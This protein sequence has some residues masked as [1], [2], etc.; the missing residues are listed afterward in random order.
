MAIIYPYVV[1]CGC[2]ATVTANLADGVNVSRTPAIRREILEGRFHKV[3]CPACGTVVTAEKS[4]FYTDLDRQTFIQVKPRQDRHLSNSV[5]AG[6]DRALEYL[7]EALSPTDSRKV[8][9]VFGMAELREK[10]LAED[11]DL[12]DRSVEYLKVLV[13]NEHPFLLQK[14]R[15]RLML[16]GATNDELQFVAAFDL[17]D[18][19]FRVGIPLPAGREVA[20]DPPLLKAWSTDAGHSD[21]G[22]A[23]NGNH[24]VNMWRWSP[25]PGALEA[26]QGFAAALRQGNPIDMKSAG[27][28]TMLEGLPRGAQLPGW[29]KTD[30]QL[31][32]NHAK[33]EGDEGVQDALFEIRF[34]KVLADDWSTN[35]ARDDI[36]TIWKLLSALPPTNVEGNSSI[37]EIRL[38]P[39][40]GGGWYEPQTG[41]IYIGSRLLSDRENFEDV[42]RH[43]VG[44]GVHEARLDEVNGWLD[45]AF[46]W[47]MF[48]P[49][50]AG[51][52]DWVALMDGWEALGVPVGERASILR[53]IETAIGR[54]E[55]WNPGPTPRVPA[56]HSWW[57]PNFGPRL[58]YERSGSHWYQNHASWYRRDGRAFFLN[59]YYRTLCVVNEDTLA[60]IAHMPSSYAAMS[61]FEFFAEL[62]ALYYDLDDPQR[63]AIRPEVRTWLDQHIGGALQRPVRPMMRAA[64]EFETV[65]RPVPPE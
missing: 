55:S 11:L 37:N 1:Q 12:D 32:F 17:E 10:L 62:Y 52:E 39:G 16:D 23:D 5:S 24:W 9:V 14:P 34:G 18:Q 6:L 25:Q 58:A 2:G 63:G 53:F 31:L 57:G 38:A 27:F 8:R 64:K 15:L 44:H 45:E 20:K 43:E 65:T 54:G 41:D 35:D 4:F 28:S 46:G 59:F 36:D 7:P 48:A 49:D 22:L 30:L 13:L 29:A 33:A 61:T 51:L 3:G 56:G 40:E 21:A 50:K 19:Q 26:L 47:R 42:I 60:L